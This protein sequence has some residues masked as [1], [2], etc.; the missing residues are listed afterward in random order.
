MGSVTVLSSFPGEVSVLWLGFCH[1]ECVNELLAA[2]EKGTSVAP[3]WHRGLWRHCAWGALLTPYLALCDNPSARAST[4]FFG[5]KFEGQFAHN[6]P[7][8][9]GWSYC[10]LRHQGWS[11]LGI[12]AM[13]WNESVLFAPFKKSLSSK[14]PWHLTWNVF[15]ILKLKYVDNLGCSYKIYGIDTSGK[16]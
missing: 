5:S 15:I 1:I 9:E 4:L 6:G 3:W 14:C 10:V 16:K 11:C 13:K 12:P 7:L 8:L 2:K